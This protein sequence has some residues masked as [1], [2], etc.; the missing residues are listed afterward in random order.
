METWFTSDLHFGHNNIIEY[1]KR[2][3]ADAVEMNEALITYWNETVH[4]DDEV[5]VLGDV[6]MGKISE[7]LP[8]VG[9]LN[10]HKFLVPGNHD[11]CWR[12]HKKRGTWLKKYV[13]AGFRYVY[14]VDSM[15]FKTTKTTV[16]L[17]HFPYE[18]DSGD[19]ERYPEARPVDRGAPLFHG[20]IHDVWKSNGKQVNVGVDVWDFRP[21]HLDQLLDL[22][23]KAFQ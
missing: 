23:P 8:L 19:E 6:A 21:A 9:R 16:L 1:C 13:E 4:P 2:P 5:Y 7:T 11:R 22:L 12:H 14:D 18:G 15:A 10:G 17:S 20:H 3:F